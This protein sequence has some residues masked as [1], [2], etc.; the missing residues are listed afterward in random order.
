[1]VEGT[2]L[3]AE[4]GDEEG[5]ESEDDEAEDDDDEGLGVAGLCGRTT[6]RPTA[7]SDGGGVL[8]ARTVVILMLHQLV[9]TSQQTP[10]CWAHLHQEC[11]QDVCCQAGPHVLWDVRDLSYQRA[12]KAQSGGLLVSN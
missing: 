6:A 8:L 1:M 9:L 12:D 10:P 4:T 2:P 7:G 3:T 11:Q 5:G